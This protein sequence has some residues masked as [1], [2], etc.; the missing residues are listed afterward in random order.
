ME[1]MSF[2]RICELLEEKKDTLARYGLE[3]KGKVDA[4][5]TVWKAALSNG[6]RETVKLCV[7]YGCK[8]DCN[9]AWKTA[10]YNYTYPILSY[11]IRSG[12]EDFLL[13]LFDLGLKNVDT[14][15]ANVYVYQQL[16][17]KKWW[18]VLERLTQLYPDRFLI[19]F[20]ED[21]ATFYEY[22]Q[23]E[24]VGGAITM[25]STKR[26]WERNTVVIQTYRNRETLVEDT[27]GHTK[28]VDFN[29]PEGV[30]L[31][32]G[33]KHECEALNCFLD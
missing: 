27:D 12:E 5:E 24:T 19:A 30:F 1:K 3:K 32:T 23:Q 17:Q 6:C 25:L 20:N 10:Y 33:I 11:A 9:P 15:D 16:F 31:A 2:V 26:H 21:Y 4:K 22:M 14:G 28:L 13:F 8:L 18:R 7:Q 29:P